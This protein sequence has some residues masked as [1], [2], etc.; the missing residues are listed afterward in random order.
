MIR[1][2][3][4]AEPIDLAAEISAIEGHGAGAV[5]T[6]SGYVR[7]DDGVI[8]LELEHYPGMTEAALTALAEDAK[9]RWSLTALSIIHRV[10]RMTPGNR[11]VLVAVAAPHRGDALAACAALI[12]QLKTKA[13]F[14][15]REGRGSGQSWVEHRATDEEAA[16]R[17]D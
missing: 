8:A 11:I 15:K 17:W 10:G 3:V 2:S 9:Q 4:Q 1:I 12:D 5:A 14:W 16:H 6:F 7:V 13:P